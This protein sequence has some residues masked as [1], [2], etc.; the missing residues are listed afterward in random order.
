STL[1]VLAKAAGS[2]V[3]VFP[4]RDDP[5]DYL[6]D[7]ALLR[8]QASCSIELPHGRYSLRVVTADGEISYTDLT[9]NASRWVSVTPAP[10]VTRDLGFT[11]GVVGAVATVLG[12]ALLADAV[13]DSCSKVARNMIG[14]LSLGIGIPMLA[15]GGSMYIAYRKASIEDQILTQT[16]S[17]SRLTKA[18]RAQLNDAWVG[19]A[20]RF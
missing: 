3:L 17:G 7:A 14:G 15:V 12:G 19:A 20:F 13:C 10:Q 6:E 1:R 11:M 16:E 4:Y 9:L 2:Q 8:C 5:E 18:T